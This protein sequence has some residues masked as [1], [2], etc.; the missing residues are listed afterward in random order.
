MVVG[1][2][3][4]SLGAASGGSLPMVN[5]PEVTSIISM[6]W[7]VVKFGYVWRSWMRAMG[8]VLMAGFF[9]SFGSAGECG[10]EPPGLAATAGVA[11]RTGAGA[12]AR[13]A[14]G[15]APGAF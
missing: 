12:R 10:M 7:R 15:A 4:C 1:R 2:G 6:P 13:G 9:G 3:G 5:W 8:E 11:G 14:A